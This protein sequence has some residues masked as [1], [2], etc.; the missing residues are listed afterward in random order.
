MD[1]AASPPRDSLLTYY[2]HTMGSN[3]LIRLGQQD[4]SAHV[5][6]RRE[7]AWLPPLKQSVCAA[8]A[9]KSTM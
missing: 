3:P 7:S 6:L 1:Y 9:G 4:I 2:R 5:D 8:A